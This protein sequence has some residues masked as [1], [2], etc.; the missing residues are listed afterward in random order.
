MN[1][2]QLHFL[3][4]VTRSMSLTQVQNTKFYFV[5]PSSPVLSQGALLLSHDNPLPSEKEVFGLPDLSLGGRGVQNRLATPTPTKRSDL[6]LV[7][8]DQAADLCFLY[9]FPLRCPGGED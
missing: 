9:H 7:V 1:M 2:P 5:Q 6:R 4:T 3:P 8:E